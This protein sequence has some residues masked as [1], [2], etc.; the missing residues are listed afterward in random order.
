MSPSNSQNF[1]LNISLILRIF[2]EIIDCNTLN[3]PNCI[4]GV[5]HFK[6]RS[7]ISLEEKIFHTKVLWLREGHKIVPLVWPAP[8]HLGWRC[9]NQ[10]KVT[11]N[12]LNGTL[13]FSLHSLITS[14]AF[15][16]TIIK[17]FFIKYFLSYKACKLP[18]ALAGISIIQSVPRGDCPV[19]FTSLLCMHTC[20]RAR[21]HVLV[22]VL[23]LVHAMIYVLYYVFVRIYQH[24]L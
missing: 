16:N 20:M 12:F 7:Q 24:S 19:G 18:H 13:Y 17:Y 21:I 3:V 9:Q 11:L 23:V 2:S 1:C 14:R 8:D 4:Y 10:S 22:I 6:R 5:S 15:Q